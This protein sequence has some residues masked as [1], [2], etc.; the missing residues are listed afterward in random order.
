MPKQRPPIIRIRPQSPIEIRRS[1]VETTK[2]NMGIAA[3]DQRIGVIGNI[4]KHMIE[5]FQ[6]ALILPLRHKRS[7]KPNS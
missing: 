5:M 3:S 4:G 7:T 1:V 6:C 2:K